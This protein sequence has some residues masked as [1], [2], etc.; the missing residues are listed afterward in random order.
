MLCYCD[1]YKHT[2]ELPIEISGKVKILMQ[3]CDYMLSNS[4]E[5]A[6]KQI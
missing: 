2:T 1:V 3:V 4:R 6:R 5:I